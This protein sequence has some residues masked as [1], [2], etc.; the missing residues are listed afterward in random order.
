MKRILLIIGA[1]CLFALFLYSPQ[2]CINGS[3]DAAYTFLYIVLPSLFP[4]F[5]AVRLLID[6]GIVAIFS[7]VLEKPTRLIFGFPGCFSYVFLCSLLSGYPAGARATCDL[8][9]SGC[10][11]RKCAEHMINA[12]S[13][14]GPMFIIGTIGAGLLRY[15]QLA[16]YVMAAH[17]ISAIITAII[18][19]FSCRTYIPSPPIQSQNQPGIIDMIYSAVMSGL[20]SMMLVGGF[21]LIFGAAAGGLES[22]PIYQALPSEA[23]AITAGCMEMTTGVVRT[24]ALP[25]QTQLIV[26]SCII[27]FGGASI[28][29]QTYSL[30]ATVG[31]RPRSFMLSKLMQTGLAAGCCVLLLKLFPPGV[32]T[33]STAFSTSQSTS[34]CGFAMAAFAILSALIIRPMINSRKN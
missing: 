20:K 22:L 28:H 10:I 19:G 4:F 16:W 32:V 5:F 3:A 25:L 13:T 31:L 8:Y 6:S 26:I 23:Q 12:A 2:A 17:I 33:V 7:R 30:C 29:L 9:K 34:Y 14:S 18:A 21:M 15:P 1:S 11:D 24:D 27:A